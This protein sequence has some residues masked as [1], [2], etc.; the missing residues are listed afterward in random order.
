MIRET[1]TLVQLSQ[2][3]SEVTAPAFMLGAVAGFASLITMRLHRILDRSHVL[4][5]ISDGDASRAHLKTEIPR[6]KCRAVLLSN[7][8]ILSTISAIVT[9]LIVIVAFASAYLNIAHEYGVG[10]LFVV[11]LA[12][13]AAA[14]V[15][16]ARET[17]IALRDMQ[18]IVNAQRSTSGGSASVPKTRVSCADSSRRD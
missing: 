1:P 13:F 5:E 6:L 9:S 2:V 11:A 7:A 3:I 12:F 14:L 15:N 10:P 16:L 18:T 8:I 4:N 17:R